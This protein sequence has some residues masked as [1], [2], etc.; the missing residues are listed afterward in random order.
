[1]IEFSPEGAAPAPTAAPLAQR[2]A[3]P[4]P[5]PPP[6]E[7]KDD[8]DSPYEG[9]LKEV[10][11]AL[12]RGDDTGALTKA[13]T[14]RR[15]SPGDVL[16]LV[17]LGETLERA[18]DLPTAARAYGSIIDLFPGRADLRRFAGARLERLDRATFPAALDLAVDTLEK[19]KDD[20]PD[21]PSS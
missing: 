5:P 6:P 4:P 3:P 2:A 9:K 10:M 11:D 15:E 21:H 18:K 12:A 13:A 7:A 1:P 19:A 14:W 16:A 17:A 20:R 8:H